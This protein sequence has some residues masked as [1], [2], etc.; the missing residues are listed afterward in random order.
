M[1]PNLR[2]ELARRRITFSHLASMIGVTVG[3]MSQKNGGKASFTLDEAIAI[4]NVL[5][6]DMPL[7]ELFQRE[8]V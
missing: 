3:T 7:E 2:A 8:E 5:E 1:Y 4:K 6:T